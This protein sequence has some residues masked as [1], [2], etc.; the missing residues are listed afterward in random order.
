M[1]EKSY[2]SYITNTKY[3]YLHRFLG[4]V[5]GFF[6]AKLLSGKKEGKQGRLKSLKFNIKEYTIHFHHWFIATLILIILILLN[7]YNDIIYGI[8]IGLIIQGLTYKDF[9]KV[10][11]FKK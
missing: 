1:K 7:F 9:Y 2:I 10:I 3:E 8:L 11:Y 5:I 4:M 6:A